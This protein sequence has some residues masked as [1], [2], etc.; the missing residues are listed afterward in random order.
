MAINPKLLFAK[1]FHSRRR[2]VTNTFN[3]GIFYL[4]LPLSGINTLKDNFWFRVNR[5]GLISFYARDH[6]SEK[7]VTL[8]EW[9][10]NTLNRF[11]VTQANGETLL[12]T[13]PRILG[14][15]F[16]PVSFWLCLDAKHQLRAVI[17]SVNNT[18][19]EKHDYVC[20]HPDQRVI[21]PADSLTAQKVFHV[22]PFIKREGDYQFR[23]AISG[24]S[25]EI[26]INY[27][28]TDGDCLLVTALGG[29]LRKMNR[30]NLAFAFFRYPLV[31]LMVIFRI[32]W[33][34][35]KLFLKRIQFI[36]KPEQHVDKVTK[37]YQ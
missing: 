25:I 5:W 1:V 2:P 37:S 35:L 29:Q 27:F 13:M 19:G 21:T 28:N 16:N 10:I 24:K 26:T 12:V 15:I 14:Y 6:V 11:G 22:S 34:A 7:K 17:C 33:Q 9:K 3:Y 23:F 18:Y 4:V 20:V 31:T 30:H 36:D 32:H 8:E